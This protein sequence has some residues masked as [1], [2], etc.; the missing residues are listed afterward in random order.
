MSRSIR[1]LPLM[2]IESKMLLPQRKVKKRRSRRKTKLNKSSPPNSY[3]TVKG[4][5]K[6]LS[7]PKPRHNFHRGLARARLRRSS[8]SASPAKQASTTT[9]CPRGSAS[10]A[11]STINLT[12]GSTISI[13]PISSPPPTRTSSAS[14]TASVRRPS[15]GRTPRAR[16]SCRKSGTSSWKTCLN[17]QGL[18]ERTS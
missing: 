18:T 1:F 9:S 4:S 10:R 13:G 17:A 11:Q 16:G 3:S 5:R 12:Q 15:A 2:P 8:F 7:R 6:A 14:A